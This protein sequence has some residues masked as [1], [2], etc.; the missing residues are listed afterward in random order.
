[1]K[2]TTVLMRFGWI[3]K[4]IYDICHGPRHQ[5]GAKFEV[6]AKPHVKIVLNECGIK[7]SKVRY[8]IF[9]E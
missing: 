7:I 4:Y 3:K 5:N 2:G 1:M 6:I 9:H 8:E